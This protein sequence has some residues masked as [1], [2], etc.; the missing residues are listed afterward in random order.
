MAGI[1]KKSFAT[2]DVINHPGE[3]L[4]LDQVSFG[5]ITIRKMTAQPGW[6]WSEHLKPVVKTENCETNHLLYIISGRI[7]S[8]MTGGEVVEFGPGDVGQVPPGHDGWVVGD[9]PAV[10]IEI[11][12]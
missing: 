11:P 7:A 5:H 10:W 3:K 2:P 8:Q 1:I 9:E 4:K 6:K 12:H